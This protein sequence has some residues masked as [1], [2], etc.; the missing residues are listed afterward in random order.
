[1]KVDHKG[2]LNALESVQPGLAKKEIVEQTNH[3][4]F[5]G[6]Y[7]MTFNGEV[8]VT[9]HFP[10]GIEGTVSADKLYPLVKKIPPDPEGEINIV[11]E[12][13]EI[14][15][16]GKG[17]KFRSGLK[18]D[19]EI[20]LD[21]QNIK[22]ANEKKWKDLPGNFIEAVQ[23]SLASAGTDM[24]RPLM[25]CIH[26]NSEL[27]E[28]NDNYRFSRMFLETEVFGDDD[29][30]IPASSM[31]VLVKYPIKKF[32]VAYTDK[33][34]EQPAFI[35]FQTNSDVVISLSVWPDEYVETEELY[36][37]PTSEIDISFPKT[38]LDALDRANIFGKGEHALDSEVII[39]LM[40]RK[41]LISAE[42]DSGWIKEEMAINYQG[43]EKI[44][45]AINPSFL[46][47]VIRQFREATVS[48]NMMRFSGSNW[49]HL[50]VLYMEE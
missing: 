23:F 2:L 38:T 34:K 28:S 22:T 46:I 41:M 29:F 35:H 36:N 21:L 42:D 14:L 31:Q 48:T 13:G 32:Q 26:F 40:K 37:S 4:V 30:V 45:F 3:F 1:M 9:K 44:K 11:M 50:I 5:D 17:N 19:P 49:D 8:G 24:S 18:F 12:E 16:S 10:T 43:K 6:E 33:S 7:I 39:Q 25:T 47:Q 27:V 20:T 15:I